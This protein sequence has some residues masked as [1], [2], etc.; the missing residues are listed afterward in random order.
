MEDQTV[1]VLFLTPWYPSE[2]DEMAGLFVQKHAD[3]VRAQGCDV[4][5]IDAPKWRDMWR[6]W[7]S[8]CQTGW[9]PD[10]VQLNVI[11]KQGLL[12]MWL[13][14]R[15]HIPYII[16]EHWS[17]YMPENGQ[18]MQKNALKR[19]MYKF[20][21]SQASYV[22]T[23]SMLLQRAMQTCGFKA[24]QWGLID[25][26][27]DDFFFQ[28]KQSRGN[29]NNETTPKTLLHVSCFDERAKNVKGLLRAAKMLSEKRRDWKLVLVGTG[30][31]YAEVRAFAQRLDIPADLLEWTG[32]LPPREVA[33]RMHRADAF[34]LSSR[35]ETYGVVLAEAVA[36]GVPVLSTPVGIAEELADIIV[37][38]EIAQN[39][40]GTF[41]E[42]MET[43]LFN[44]EIVQ[45]NK[46]NKGQ[47][48][49]LYL[50]RFSAEAVGRKLKDIYS[51]VL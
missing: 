11:Q 32:E 41:A 38:Q 21:C 35:Y 18:M 7:K 31:N 51:N 25:N 12:A 20:I 40:P 49:N 17:G 1:R 27:V 3:A 33:D 37:P 8:L 15:Y 5:V 4:K 10:I 30:V 23:V 26:V 16:V 36:A 14:W 42:F 44:N 6:Q 45:R 24:R 22:L 19:R 2:R 34:V 47:K 39:K 29:E 43:I 28:A 13:K 46:A 9:R 50:E 48:E